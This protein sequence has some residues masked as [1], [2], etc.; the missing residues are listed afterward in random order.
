M[1]ACGYYALAIYY[2]ALAYILEFIERE[3][4]SGNI[5]DGLRF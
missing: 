2:Y 1:L 3:H 5:Y 4:N